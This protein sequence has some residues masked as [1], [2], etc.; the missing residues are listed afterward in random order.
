VI[1]KAPTKFLLDPKARG[2]TVVPPDYIFPALLR[3]FG[4]AGPLRSY[5]VERAS[6]RLR[7]CLGFKGVPSTHSANLP[8]WRLD[9]YVADQQAARAIMTTRQ[10]AQ[11]VNQQR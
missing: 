1:N 7:A 8:Y 6:R 9:Q 11:G 2:K 3:S 4:T 10:Q 5:A